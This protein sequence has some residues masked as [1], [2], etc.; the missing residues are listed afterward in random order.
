MVAMASTQ[1]PRS[2]DLATVSVK[3]LFIRVDGI[4]HFLVAVGSSADDQYHTYRQRFCRQDIGQLLYEL[5]LVIA[6][7]FKKGTKALPHQ[8]IKKKRIAQLINEKLGENQ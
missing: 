3:Y 7:Y 2:R 4:I 6:E 1:K 8:L 5:E